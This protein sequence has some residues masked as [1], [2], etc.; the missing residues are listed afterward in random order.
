MATLGPPLQTILVLHLHVLVDL[1]WPF[2][3]PLAE[4]GRQSWHWAA[5]DKQK[6]RRGNQQ[7]AEGKQKDY[8]QGNQ[9][10]A[11]GWQKDYWRGNQQ[12]AEG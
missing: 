3:L 9:Q 12:A 11:E 6:S 5:V 10:A 1:L 4:A 8:W 2:E 7:V